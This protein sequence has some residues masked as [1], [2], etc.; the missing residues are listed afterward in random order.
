MGK[1]IQTKDK[2]TNTQQIQWQSNK[3][4]TSLC[5]IIV[6]GITSKS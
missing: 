1:Q 2:K 5:V 6:L 4:D 3:S